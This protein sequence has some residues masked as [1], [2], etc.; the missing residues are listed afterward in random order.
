[1]ISDNAALIPDPEEGCFLCEP[2]PWR[3]IF[4]GEHVRVIVGLG[5]ICPGYI[6][7]A[8]KGHYH[9]TVELNNE[10][11]Y[12]FCA[13]SNIIKNVLSTHYGPGYTA[14][15]H[16]KIGACLSREQASDFST[17]CHHCHRV[18]IPHASDCL[19]L[20]RPRFTN[21]TSLES[22]EDIRNCEKDEYI[23]YETSKG[24][25]ADIRTI[26]TGVSALPS[27]FMRRL[28]IKHL[29]M[30]RDYSWATA[31][32]YE[33]MI[34]TIGRLR[35]S[36]IGLDTFKDQEGRH[37][38]TNVP[39]S[40]SFDG[41]AR[42]GK[43]S[44]AVAVGSCMERPVID[45]GLIFRRMALAKAREEPWPDAAELIRIIK[46]P[47]KEMSYHTPEI[48]RR[49]AEMAADKDIRKLY[50]QLAQNVVKK[51]SP[52][53]LVGRDTWKFVPKDSPSFLVFADIRTRVYREM[54]QEAREN[55]L[56]CS[57]EGI[58]ERLAWDD[59]ADRHKL[60][61]ADTPGLN[62]LYNGKRLFSTAVEEALQ[63]I[64]Q[65]D[66]Q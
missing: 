55:N 11:F 52:V 46:D 54:L 15:E 30:E 20:L 32:Y 23:Y 37:Q 1:M 29:G 34:A 8:P 9:T 44:I 53:V 16:G 7:L 26:L 42:A 56:L 50:E 24:R 38:E 19:S 18:F 17:F 49:A 39:G 2:E 22:A 25:E 45:T 6:L 60:P 57:Y 5:P 64:G 61:N 65:N 27:Q 62:H 14:Y 58:T 28:L 47:Q 63:V 10:T 33:E 43:T 35:S 36:F 21:V 59:D 12:E 40:I 41:H 13:V 3:V 31:P 4:R 48:S 51:M 66:E